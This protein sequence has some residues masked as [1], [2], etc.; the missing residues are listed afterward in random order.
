MMGELYYIFNVAVFDSMEL[1]EKIRETV[2][3][4][5]LLSHEDHQQQEL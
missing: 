4:I 1:K 5:G 2:S 3:K